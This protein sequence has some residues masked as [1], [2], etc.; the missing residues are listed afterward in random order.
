MIKLG[1][2][3]AVPSC[4]LSALQRSCQ[5]LRLETDRF[6]EC[7]QC[8]FHRGRV[9]QARAA[10]RR[11]R[12]YLLSTCSPYPTCDIGGKEGV[13]AVDSRDG[14][15]SDSE[16]TRKRRHRPLYKRLAS[17]GSHEC[18]TVGRTQVV[19]GSNMF[20]GREWQLGYSSTMASLR[21]V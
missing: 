1:A 17:V 9:F 14:H 4:S 18:Q 20:H 19:W 13:A 5:D 6:V 10:M 21:I 7:H 2:R 12:S 16:R 8:F 3:N 11:S 15:I